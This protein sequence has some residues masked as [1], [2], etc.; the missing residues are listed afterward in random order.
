M[1]SALVCK[2]PLIAF[3]IAA[4]ARHIFGSAAQAVSDDA[5]DVES[6]FVGVLLP[7]FFLL[8]QAKQSILAG[9]PFGQ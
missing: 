5:V 9:K 4:F 3:A 1:V 8:L 7:F 6:A 2:S